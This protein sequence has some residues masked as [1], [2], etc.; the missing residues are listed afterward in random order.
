MGYYPFE[1]GIGFAMRGSE[2]LCA[3]KAK[4]LLRWQNAWRRQSTVED[5]PYVRRF[6]TGKVPKGPT[7]TSDQ[8]HDAL[9]LKARNG[10]ACVASFGEQGCRAVEWLSKGRNAYYVCTPDAPLSLGS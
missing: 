2:S 7:S 10:R 4:W 6:E 1:G 9:G 8:S 5:T 3:L